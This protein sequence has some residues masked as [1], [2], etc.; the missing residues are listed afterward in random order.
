MRNL[1][2]VLLLGLVVGLGMA[3]L[4]RMPW[5]VLLPGLAVGA[6]L[7]WMIWSDDIRQEWQRGRRWPGLKL[8]ARDLVGLAVAFA[9]GRLLAGLAAG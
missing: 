3:G 6:V 9:V 8:G 7:H 4:M 5:L 2:I 1:G